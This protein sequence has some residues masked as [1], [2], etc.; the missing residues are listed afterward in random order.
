LSLLSLLLA[1][2]RQKAAEACLDDPDRFRPGARRDACNGG[3]AEVHVGVFLSVV[4]SVC[5]D[6]LSVSVREEVYR[7]RRDDVDEG[8]PLNNARD[9]QVA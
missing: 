4:E 3:G 8:W 9:V 6:L 5:E 1:C 7:P 2:P